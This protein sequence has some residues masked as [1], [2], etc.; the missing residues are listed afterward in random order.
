[1]WYLTIFCPCM[2]PELLLQFD[3]CN[4]LL[5]VTYDSQLNQ[6]KRFMKGP[7]FVALTLNVVTCNLY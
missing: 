5:W 4:W 1:M 2:I 6:Q 3:Y 7:L